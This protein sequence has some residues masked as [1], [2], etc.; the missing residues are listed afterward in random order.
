MYL[1]KFLCITLHL[2]YEFG[3]INTHSNLVVFTASNSVLFI[4]A[5]INRSKGLLI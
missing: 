4:P 5:C 1:G 3:V 2:A